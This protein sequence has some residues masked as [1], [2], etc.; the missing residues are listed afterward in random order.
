[1]ATEAASEEPSAGSATTVPS[2]CTAT[3]GSVDAGVTDVATG[4]AGSGGD[5]STLAVVRTRPAATI[6]VDTLVVVGD[7]VVVAPATMGAGLTGRG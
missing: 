4:V 6:G 3:T 2:S 5:W 1:M 7:V